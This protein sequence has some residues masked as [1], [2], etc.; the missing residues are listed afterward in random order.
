MRGKQL[1]KTFVIH[2][3]TDL[4]EHN[5][6]LCY[7][8][9]VRCKTIGQY[10]I[11]WSWFDR[12]TAHRFYGFALPVRI[13]LV[14]RWWKSMSIS[15]GVLWWYIKER[16][17]SSDTVFMV[18]HYHSSVPMSFC[19]RSADFLNYPK[20]RVSHLCWSHAAVSCRCMQVTITNKS[21]N[22]AK[23]YPACNYWNYWSAPLQWAFSG[24]DVENY[25]SVKRCQVLC[26]VR[27]TSNL[28]QWLHGHETWYPVKRQVTVF[29]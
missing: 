20:G 23:Q 27:E 28:I 24:G 12:Y 2:F 16:S 22:N 18:D 14:C 25:W 1:F 3:K 19:T 17:Q 6:M 29:Q 11:W 5:Q 9:N 8:C 4:I 13:V 26:R 10:A 15:I 7:Q 21:G